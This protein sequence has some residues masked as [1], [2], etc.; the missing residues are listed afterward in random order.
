MN[1]QA[2][3]YLQRLGKAQSLEERRGV[4]TEFHA[5]VATLSEPEK[6]EVKAHFRTLIDEERRR[7]DEL[8]T[9]MSELRRRHSSE[10][11]S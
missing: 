1:P 10:S 3:D 7:L 5:F 4:A 9:M 11:V 8:E 6:A 2:I